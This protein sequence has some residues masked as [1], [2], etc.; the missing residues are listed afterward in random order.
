MF[1]SCNHIGVAVERLPSLGNLGE[2]DRGRH[3]EAD[4]DEHVEDVVI[5]SDPV[6][7]LHSNRGKC[8]GGPRYCTQIAEFRG[9][10]VFKPRTK[11]MGADATLRPTLPPAISRWYAFCIQIADNFLVN[12]VSDLTTNVRDF[13]AMNL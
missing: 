1:A 13:S 2:K 3:D 5:M 6:V 11:W 12:V 10:F 7:T 4:D 8:F 9:V